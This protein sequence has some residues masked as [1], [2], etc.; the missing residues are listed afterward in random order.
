MTLAGL[1]RGGKTEDDA[2]DAL[3]AYVP[4]YEAVARAA[5]L[6][7]EYPRT[8]VLDVVERYEGTGST[9]FWGISFGFSSIDHHPLPDGELERHLRLV[10]ACWAT[11][12]NVRRRVSAEMRR[13]PRGGDRQRDQIVRHVLAVEQDWGKKVGVRDPADA[14][15][16]DDVGLASILGKAGSDSWVEV[17]SG[18]GSR[19]AWSVRPTRGRGGRSRGSRRR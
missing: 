4:R 17:L 15:I 14:V 18:A 7:G 16:Q 10:Q 1:E 13:G 12:D 19:S 11:F 8:P 2:L 5:A 3:A 6:H 9:D